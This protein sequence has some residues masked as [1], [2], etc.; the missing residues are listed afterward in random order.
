MDELD[1]GMNLAV[2]NAEELLLNRHK[3]EV[4]R[5]SYQPQ[6][7][8]QFHTLYDQLAYQLIFW[9]GSGGCGVLQSEKP[10][11][12][13]ALIRKVLISIILRPRDHFTPQFKHLREEFTCTVYG[14]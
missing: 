12:L 3:M 1:E 4:L 13:A 8:R 5:N 10:Q 9:S 7:L 6:K 2:F 14:R 11:W